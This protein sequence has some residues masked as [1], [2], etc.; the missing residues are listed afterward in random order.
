MQKASL[1]VL[2]FRKLKI[3][4]ID[5]IGFV[6]TD[7][8]DAIDAALRQFP[9][10][11]FVPLLPF[12]GKKLVVA[13]DP[14]QLEAVPQHGCSTEGNSPAFFSRSWYRVIEGLGTGHVAFFTST[15]R[16]GKDAEFP[17]ILERTRYGLPNLSDIHV[18][19][20]TSKGIAHP[21][22]PPPPPASYT[23]SFPLKR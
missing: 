1:G 5:E 23:L 22:G 9:P 3:L 20:A 14:F 17:R 12:G 8:S 2:H 15:Y 16:H 11:E 13:G 10:R 19:N 21:P 4:V 18:L 7:V 6:T